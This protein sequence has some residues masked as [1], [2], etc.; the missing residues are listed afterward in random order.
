MHSLELFENAIWYKFYK[1]I[2]KKLKYENSGHYLIL[3]RQHLI[4]VCNP[5]FV[6]ATL[7]FSIDLQDISWNSKPLE[8]QPIVLLL[9]LVYEL[10]GQKQNYKQT[11]HQFCCSTRDR[12]TGSELW[13]AC[14]REKS[15]VRSLVMENPCHPDIKRNLGKVPFNLPITQEITPLFFLTRAVKEH[16]HFVSNQMPMRTQFKLKLFN[17]VTRG[18]RF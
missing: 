12:N 10:T 3:Q 8:K 11:I 16:Q 1:Q 17:D 9:E 14:D 7:V 13:K 4:S 15:R 2:N 6:Q 5:V 18:K